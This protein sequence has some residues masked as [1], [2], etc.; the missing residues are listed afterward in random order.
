MAGSAATAVVTSSGQERS[1]GRIVDDITLWT[2]I[3]KDLILGHKNFKNIGVII[4]EARVL[5]T[6]DVQDPKIRKEASKIVWGH[7]GVKE[8][9]NEIQ[10][11]DKDGIGD[12]IKD[13]AITTQVKGRLLLA[14]GVKYSNHKLVTVNNIV[15]LVGIAQNQEELNQVTDIASR[16]AGV[17]KV[18][19]Y[20][21]LRDSS[22]R[23]K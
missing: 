9:I 19:S 15:Y 4:H 7:E 2:A 23:K 3:K 16:V 1:V 13:T 18:V 22:L 6:G 14:K 21:R 20:V 10:I 8:V 5:L 17:K 11:A 12:A